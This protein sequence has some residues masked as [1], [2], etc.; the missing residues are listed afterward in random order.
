[1]VSR[2]GESGRED[3]RSG[4][5]KSGT[6][7]PWLGS[8]PNS[9]QA[10]AGSLS[11]ISRSFKFTEDKSLSRIKSFTAAVVGGGV[12]GWYSLC[13]AWRCCVRPLYVRH[14]FRQPFTG[15]MSLAG[16]QSLWDML[17]REPS[18][19]TIRWILKLDIETNSEFSQVDHI[20][21]PRLQMSIIQLPTVN[22]Q[23]APV[24][25]STSLADDLN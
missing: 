5:S 20:S 25:N 11:R 22:S 1:M 14:S 23:K 15:Q 7:L 17:K 3:G 16:G 4:I 21:I 2:D 13:F 9:S 10:P 6:T 12:P 24:V 18:A 8:V 19:Y